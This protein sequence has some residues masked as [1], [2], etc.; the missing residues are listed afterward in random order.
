MAD[1]Q[2]SR[3]LYLLKDK[4]ILRLKDFLTEGVGCFNA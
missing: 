3:A 4:G 1:T 2:K